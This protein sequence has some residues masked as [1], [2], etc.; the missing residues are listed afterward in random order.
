MRYIIS[1]GGTGGGVYPALAVV[2][3]LQHHDPDTKIVWIGSE[4]GPER[5]IVE[6][7]HLPFEA[8][9]GGPII[10]VGARAF[11]SSVQLA[12]GTGQAQAVILKFKPDATLSTGG[13]P[14]IPPTLASWGRC[15]I[16]INM[17]DSEPSA[18]IKMLA[19]IATKIAVTSEDSLHYFPGKAIVT[20]YP[21][22]AEL[23]QAAGFDPLGKPL[24]SPPDT[25]SQARTRFGLIP[26]MPT[27]LITGGSKGARS[28]NEALLRHLPDLLP[29]CQ[30]VHISG[31]LDWESVQTRV[32]EMAKSMPSEL[33]ARYHGA[34]YL[35]S[36]DMALA[37]AAADLVVSRAGAS[38]LGEFPLFGLPA[39]LVPYPHAWRYQKTNAD[40]LSERGAAIRLEDE[41]LAENLA[42]TILRVLSDDSERSRMSEAMR[43][44]ARPDAAA[45]IADLLIEMSTKKGHTS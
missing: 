37:L 2:E 13:W 15:P 30:I 16:L 20:G 26:D 12:W 36:A 42:P 22:R 14:T 45:R 23:L 33:A 4:H 43:S 9:P 24:D 7:Q 31:T 25:R 29:N 41:H 3:S 44:L 34:G 11:S 21:I 19:R 35:H 40:V 38:V 18:S 10:G 1:G 39:I 27:V 17:P 8:V 28:L 6:R 32:A 5:E